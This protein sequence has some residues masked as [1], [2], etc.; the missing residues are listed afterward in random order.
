MIIFAIA[1]VFAFVGGLLYVSIGN[2]G[3][4]TPT[5]AKVAELAR[6]TFAAAMFAIMFALTLGLH[7]ELVRVVK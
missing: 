2:T 4:V 1:V 5:G 7:E 6:I 3:T